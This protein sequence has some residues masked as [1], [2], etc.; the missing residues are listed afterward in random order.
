MLRMASLAWR[1]AEMPSPAPI[2]SIAVN[3]KRTTNKLV[4]TVTFFIIFLIV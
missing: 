2:T 4:R 3:D 1:S